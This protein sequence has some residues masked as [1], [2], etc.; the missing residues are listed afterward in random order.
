MKYEIRLSGAVQDD[1]KIDLQ[2]L[3]LLAQSIADIAKGALQIRLLGISAEKGRTSERISNALKISLSNLK[4]GSTILE[5]ECEQFKKTLD[6]YQGDAFRPEVLGNLPDETPMSLVMQSYREALNYKEEANHLD[7]ALLK[8]LKTVEKIFLSKEEAITISNQGR[9]PNLQLKKVDFKK[10]Q[11]LEES[12]PEPQEIVINGVVEELKYSKLKVT[13]NTKEGPVIGILS[14]NLDPLE[15]SK[16][17]GKDL[18]IAGTANYQPSG[19]LSVIY[20]ERLF[21]P[22]DTD[23]YFSRAGR[24]ET[25]EQQIHRQQKKLKSSN[26]LNEIVGQWPGDE[27]IDEIINALD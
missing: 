18:T 15:I 20:I 10:I 4:P 6:G 3:V 23:K 7:K 24:K 25:V 16:Y 14:E 19:R 12:I 13:I 11:S 9:T 2:R 1:G 5:L 22:D 21:E 8:K 17:W 26:H 27:N